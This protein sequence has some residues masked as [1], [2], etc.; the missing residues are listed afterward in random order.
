MRRARPRRRHGVAAL[1]TLVV[2]AVALVAADVVARKLA[3][4]ELAARL[5]G[6]VP[7]AA[8]ATATL[9]SFPFLVRLLGSGRVGEVD[10]AVGDITV[11]GLRFAS[12]AVDLHGVQLDR[13][14]LVRDRRLVLE[15]IDRGRVQARVSE[16]A[17]TEALGVPVTLEQ[18]RASVTIA[19]RTLG[20]DLA[21]QNG[22]LK[23]GVAGF[24]LPTI[25]VAAPLLPCVAD[26]RIDPGLVLL[27]CDFTEIPREL[28]AP[29]QL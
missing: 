22:R 9:R 29:A 10:A 3:E 2:L 19:G 25:H 16:E 11:E 28:R 5:K 23:V 24:S 21:V 8:T 14:Q 17:L 7:T 4:D 26:A 13:D 18:G 6:A 27:T 15:K 12:I 20:A 1:L